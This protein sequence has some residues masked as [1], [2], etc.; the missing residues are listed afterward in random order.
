MALLQTTDPL[1]I[2]FLVLA[3][4]IILAFV[5]SLHEAAHAYFANLLGDP[6]A[7]LLGRVTLNPTAHIDPI[8]TVLVPLI[9]LIL[10]L[11]T[12]G[13]PGFIF[14]WAKPTPI[15]PLN[16]RRPRRDSAITAFAGPASN[17]TLAF[18]VGFIS[19]LIPLSSPDKTSIVGLALSRQFSALFD[20]IDGSTTALIFLILAV[21]IVLNLI[22]AIF[23]LLPIPPLDGYKILIGIVPRETAIRLSVLESYGPII[24]IIFIFFFFQ[25]LSPAISGIL[26][27]L[28][29][30]LTGTLL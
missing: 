5:I 21:I 18:V 30:F 17:L 2:F 13:K 28:L 11:I 19:R 14:G 8:G 1:T 23:N 24:L 26:V 3:F 29:N 4:L 27:S 15:N 22:L 7:R 12:T 6:T 16:F 9:L 10:P 20:L 25:F